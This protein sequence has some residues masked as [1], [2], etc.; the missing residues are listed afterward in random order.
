MYVLA[1]MYIVLGRVYRNCIFYFNLDCKS[2]LTGRLP[3]FRELVQSNFS[4]LFR[5]LSAWFRENI[6]VLFYYMMHAVSAGRKHKVK[7]KVL[8][9]ENLL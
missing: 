9:L 4:R 8:F 7:M 1:L 2:G 6:P 3:V 5:F